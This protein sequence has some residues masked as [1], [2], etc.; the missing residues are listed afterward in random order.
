MAISKRLRYEIL[1]RDQNRC[2]YCKTAESRLTIDHVVPVSL[3]GSDEPSNLVAAC[4][5]CNAGKSASNPDAP[6]VAEV[7]QRAAEFAIAISKVI[8][9][10]AAKYAEQTNL[11]TWFDRI[12]CG[13]NGGDGL[14]REA[15]WE[16]SVIQFAAAGLSRDFLHR[17]V[18]SA[19]GK[20]DVRHQHVWKY[21]CGICW[22]EIKSIRDEAGGLVSTR[23]A[24]PQ[25]SNRP[26]DDFPY[27]EMFDR[28]LDDL[29]PALGGTEEM[30]QLADWA[31]WSA[32][33]E[34]HKTW[35]SHSELESGLEEAAETLSMVTARHMYE[36]GELRKRGGQTDGS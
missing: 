20:R 11:A 7:D 28:F 19:I 24:A 8:E 16:S 17:A 27:M 30:R 12:W 13:P 10:R 32:M 25:A 22:K 1:R 29:L 36:I 2:W 34:A 15:G 18:N 35:H 9:Q 21:F 33:P 6:L 14:P 4:P 26:T 23:V 3:G 5:D 31:L